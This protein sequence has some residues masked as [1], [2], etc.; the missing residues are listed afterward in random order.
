MKPTLAFD[1][2]ELL[3]GMSDEAMRGIQAHRFRGRRLT[4]FIHCVK[5]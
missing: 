1:V 4:Q 2:P 3:I 5:R